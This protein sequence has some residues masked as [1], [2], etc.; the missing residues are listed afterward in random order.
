M[1]VAM[2]VM[3]GLDAARQIRGLPWYAEVPIV[4]LSVDRSTEDALQCR[5]AGM[6]EVTLLPVLCGGMCHSERGR[7]HKLE[8]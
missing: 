6:T 8:T 2:P 5:E 1:D 3:G 7:R 4:G